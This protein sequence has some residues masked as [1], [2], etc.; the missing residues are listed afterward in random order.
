MFIRLVDATMRLRL[1]VFSTRSSPEA[2]L[3]RFSDHLRRSVWPESMLM[4]PW[5]ICCF[6]A[7]ESD[8][9]LGDFNGSSG[10]KTWRTTWA[11]LLPSAELDGRRKGL[12]L[13]S[14]P[15]RRLRRGD[16]G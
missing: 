10:R 11:I 15:Q 7:E 4:G 9:G 3:Q 12:A 16:R 14:S 2:G 5:V 6:V 8:G 1:R 13:S